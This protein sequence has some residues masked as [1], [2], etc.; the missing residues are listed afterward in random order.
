[1]TLK[2]K[3]NLYKCINKFLKWKIEKKNKD[4][5]LIL[6]FAWMERISKQYATFNLHDFCIIYLWS[7]YLSHYL[8]RILRIQEPREQ[9]RGSHAQKET[10]YPICNYPCLKDS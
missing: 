1:M 6:N 5:T 8:L 3:L 7:I 2:H 4:K 10:R 9:A